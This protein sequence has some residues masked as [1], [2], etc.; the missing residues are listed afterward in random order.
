MHHTEKVR[1][2]I[3]VIKGDQKELEGE[4]VCLSKLCLLDLSAKAKFF[5]RSFWRG[6]WILLRTVFTMSKQDVAMRDPDVTRLLH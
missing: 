5:E 4:G 2:C 6:F 1:W 3:D